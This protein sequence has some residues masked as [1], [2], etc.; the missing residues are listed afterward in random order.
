MDRVIEGR[1]PVRGT[2]SVPGDK[3]VSH[4]AAILGAVARGRS[5][6]RGLSSSRDVASTVEAVRTLGVR[7]CGEGNALVVDG[8]GIS[9][10]EALDAGGPYRIDCGNSGTTAR[11]LAGLLSG[12]GIRAALT[13]D[14]SLSGRPMG[15]VVDPLVGFGARVESRGGRLPVELGGVKPGAFRYRLPVASAQ[16]KSALLC[17]ALFLEGTCTVIEPERTRDHTERMLAL[18]GCPIDVREADP[19]GREIAIEGRGELR[20][21]DLSVP[22]DISSA[23]FLVAAALVAPRSE[24]RVRNVLLN[25]TRSKILDVFRAMGG[26]IEVKVREESPEPVGDVRARSSRLRGTALGGADIPLVIDEIPALAAAAFFAEGET[27]VSGAEEL[28]VKESDRVKGIVDIIRAF[29]GEVEE[30][31]DGFVMRGRQ[32]ARPAEAESRGDHRLAMAASVVAL[33]TE[34][35]SLVRDAGCV[36]ISFPGFFEELERLR[37]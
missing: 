23:A 4:R 25:E 6:I 32:R 21:L 7:L 24:V 33:N 3:S 37:R 20:P 27:I 22:G 17:C 16:V 30:L 11:L 36:D 29:G 10:F 28:R 1:G 34:G 5:V 35:R 18:M 8:G 14:E 31:A 15:R 13:G 19:K 12:A 26:D 9:G 2:V